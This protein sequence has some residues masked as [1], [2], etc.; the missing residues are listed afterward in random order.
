MGEFGH[1]RR[2]VTDFSALNLDKYFIGSKV[3]PVDP[4]SRITGAASKTRA[5]IFPYSYFTIT[6]SNEF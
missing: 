6:C 3:W 2:Q 4:C 5:L 1:S